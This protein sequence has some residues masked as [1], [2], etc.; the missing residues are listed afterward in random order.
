MA[1][2]LAIEVFGPGDDPNYRSHWAF[3]IYR[4]G[5]DFGDLLHVQVIDLK[6]LWYEPDYREGT[7]IVTPMVSYQ[8]AGMCKVTD[9]DGQQRRKAIEVIRAEPAPRDGKRRCQ[10]W[11]FD[12]LI[13]LEVEELVES[14]TAETWKGRIGMPASDLARA[15][16]ADWTSFKDADYGQRRLKR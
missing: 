15:C 10:D 9:L 12:T 3:L 8:A 16:G 5:D 13:S 4:P 6:R 11:V 14:G 1:Y 7:N 2:R